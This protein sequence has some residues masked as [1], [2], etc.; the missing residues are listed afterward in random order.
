[1]FVPSGDRP[2]TLATGFTSSAARLFGI[3]GWLCAGICA[4]VRLSTSVPPTSPSDRLLR[5]GACPGCI[6][7]RPRRSGRG[8]RG[9]AVSGVRGADN[10]EQRHVLIDRKDLAAAQRP[11]AGREVAGEHHDLANEGL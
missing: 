7:A 1:M 10:R 4:I 11:A 2:G 6:G 8:E 9:L 3:A 5:P